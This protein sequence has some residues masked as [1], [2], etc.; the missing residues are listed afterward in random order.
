MK[1]HWL[2]M[3]LLL[4]GC[5]TTPS[6]KEKTDNILQQ[7]YDNGRQAYVGVPTNQ[8]GTLGKY[9]NWRAGYIAGSLSHNHFLIQNIDYTYR[10][11]ELNTAGKPFNG[12]DSEVKFD[13][14]KSLLDLER[15]KSKDSFENEVE[16]EE[17]I[18]E[19]KLLY[20]YGRFVVIVYGSTLESIS[21]G[22][23]E[24]LIA[25]SGNKVLSQ[26]IEGVANVPS[27]TGLWWN[28][29]VVKSP[30]LSGQPFVLRVYQEFSGKFSSYVFDPI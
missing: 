12:I 10:V 20:P 27:I 8:A 7:Q 11:D 19:T 18:T 16:L 5:Q 1:K 17:R 6:Y 2:L 24:V 23:V 9:W 30:D 22:S 3:A 28:L 13:S 4:G 29:T 21:N 26:N 15:K 14:L 25:Q